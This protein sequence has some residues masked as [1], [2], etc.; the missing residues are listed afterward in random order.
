MSPTHFIEFPLPLYLLLL[1]V[2]KVTNFG[3]L[4]PTLQLMLPLPS[5]NPITNFLADLP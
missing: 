2:C 4:S 1:A 5:S 3:L